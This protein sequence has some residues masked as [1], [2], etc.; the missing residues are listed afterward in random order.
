MTSKLQFRLISCSSEDP[1]YPISDLIS[2]FG[3]WQS[4]RFCL[5]PQELIIQ[6][7]SPVIVNQIQF[8]SHQ[9][10]IA[11][12][13]EIFTYMPHFNNENEAGI[14]FRKMGFLKFDSNEKNRFSSRELKSVFMELPCLYMKMRIFDNH[15]NKFNVFNQVFQSL[16]YFYLRYG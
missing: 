5:F 6:F 9:F 3:E 10:K 2:S 11:S 13:I 16:I 12:K 1:Q 8:L 14:Q 15:P 4:S 7:L